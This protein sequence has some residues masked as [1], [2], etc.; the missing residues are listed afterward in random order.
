ME[1]RG[2]KYCLCIREILEGNPKVK[3]FS[4]QGNEFLVTG[5]VVVEAALVLGNL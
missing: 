5:N 1:V 4:S 3:W 2:N